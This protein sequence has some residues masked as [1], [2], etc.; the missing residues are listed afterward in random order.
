M[1]LARNALDIF[2][3][4]PDLCVYEMPLANETGNSIGFTSSK[5]RYRNYFWAD[6]PGDDYFSYKTLSNNYQKV[7]IMIVMPHNRG[8]AYNAN[9]EAVFDTSHQI[10]GDPIAVDF[11]KMIFAYLIE[12][13][14]SYENVVFLNLCDRLYNESVGEG[15]AYATA[16][17]NNSIYSFTLDTTHLNQKGA[18]VYE[19]YLLPVFHP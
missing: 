14:S 7:P 3:R 1:L 2:E 5:T 13:L 4:N 10:S 11:Y 12:N 17:G 15:I 19:K 6:D 18:Y 9:N 16:F 8:T